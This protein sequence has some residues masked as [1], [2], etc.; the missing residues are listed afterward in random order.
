M[1]KSARVRGSEKVL[2]GRLLDESQ[3]VAL[4]KLTKG[5]GIKVVDWCI[6]GQ[7]GPDGV[8]GTV[9]VGSAGVGRLL[10][11]LVRLERLRLDLEVFPLGIPAPTLFEVRF[12]G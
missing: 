9:H 6:L 12:R 10:G 5:R 1:A 2:K 4:T 7:P 3:L 11:Q 8:C